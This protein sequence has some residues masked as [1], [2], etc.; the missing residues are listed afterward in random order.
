MDLE[1]LKTNW[2]AFGDQDPLWAIITDP[3]QMGDEA[4]SESLLLSSSQ[5]D[6]AG[7]KA[8]N[9]CEALRLKGW[10]AYTFHDRTS[11]IVTVGS[12][13]ALGKT[14]RYGDVIEYLP[15]IINI[16][17]TFA[18]DPQKDKVVQQK[19]APGETLQAARSLIGIPFLQTPEPMEV[20][21]TYIR[22]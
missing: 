10:E 15:E 20:P 22:F 19:L 21:K 11:S 1:L 3:K 4:K 9:L 7:N 13:N 12:F 8:E 6:R 17:A 16:Y 5:L 2:E 18:W 14:D